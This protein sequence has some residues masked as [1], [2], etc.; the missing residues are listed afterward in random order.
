MKILSIFAFVFTKCVVQL[1]FR[2]A[3]GTENAARRVVHNVVKD[4]FSDVFYEAH[5]QSVID[6]HVLIL[7]KPIER[8]EACRKYLTVAQYMKV[9]CSNMFIFKKFV[10]TIYIIHIGKTLVGSKDSRSMEV[11]CRTAL[12]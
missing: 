11:V 4:S 9:Q 7:K 1:Y 12:V 10:S 6:Y 3:E 8:S 2:W 5:I